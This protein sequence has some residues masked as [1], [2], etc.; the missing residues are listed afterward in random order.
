MLRWILS[1]EEIFAL[2]VPQQVR[3]GCFPIW[4]RPQLPVGVGMC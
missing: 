1:L 3:Q 2:T 4:L